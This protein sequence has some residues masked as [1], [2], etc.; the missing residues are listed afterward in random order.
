VFLYIQPNLNSM[1]LYDLQLPA[2]KKRTHSSFFKSLQKKP[3]SLLFVVALVSSVFG[4]GAGIAG[5][6]FVYSYVAQDIQLPA[7]LQRIVERQTVV[8]R[9]YIPQT[10]QE[11]KIIEVVKQASPA[12]VS[13]V[14]T[15]D[16]PVIE[17]FFFQPFEDVPLQIPQFRQQGTQKQEVGGGTGFLVSPTG[18]L[19]TNKHVVLDEQAEYTVFTTDGKS[20]PA[21]VL[22]RDPFQDIAVLQITQEQRIDQQ[23][24]I[25]FTSFPFVKLGNADTLEIGQTVVAIG[26]ALAEFRNTVSVGVI[27]GLGRTITASGGDFVET[28][29]NIIQTDAAINKGNSGG[30]LLNL[31]GEVIGMNTAT[32]LQAQNIGF[33][34]PV[35]KVIRDVEQVQSIG[36]IVYPFLGIRYI[37]LSEAVAEKNN[38][39]VKQGA[40]IQKGSNGETA[41]VPGSAAAQAGIQEGDIIVEFNGEKITQENTLAKRI[42]Q[43]NPGDSVVLKIVRQGQERIVNAILQEQS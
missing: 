16:V 2:P 29:E 7:S 1:S 30:P 9:E 42:Q 10:S 33:A 11:Q 27:S 38:L 13:I 22:A 8:E 18:L 24:N 26:N 43:H 6:V 31:A 3:G 15:K 34:V 23:G 39:S 28:L 36:K 25:H 32:V 35:N 40:W 20:Y 4:L 12:V 17:Q 41:V 21:K 14:I 5:G 37:L 19:V